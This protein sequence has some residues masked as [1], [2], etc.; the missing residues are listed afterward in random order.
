MHSGL[1]TEASDVLTKDPDIVLTPDGEQFLQG[2]TL[3]NSN[4]IRQVRILLQPPSRVTSNQAGKGVR[5]L[6]S[7]YG[8]EGIAAAADLLDWKNGLVR[9][10]TIGSISQAGGQTELFL[11]SIMTYWDN[12][13]PKEKESLESVLPSVLQIHARNTTI[14]SYVDALAARMIADSGRLVPMAGMRLAG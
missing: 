1:S 12:F 8:E 11:A 14:A 5:A 10:Y 3:S 13:I 9:L 6:M 4:V 7:D 2:M